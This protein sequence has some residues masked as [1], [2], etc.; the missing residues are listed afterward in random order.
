MLELSTSL[1]TLRRRHGADV[2][3]LI[4]FV[5]FARMEGLSPERSITLGAQ[6]PFLRMIL[7]WH[8]AIFRR[9]QYSDETKENHC[10]SENLISDLSGKLPST[11]ERAGKERPSAKAVLTKPYRVSSRLVPP[12]GN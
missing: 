2:S 4:S 6:I 1:S 8:P 5:L 3:G 12:E 11:D 9:N 7:R 10:R